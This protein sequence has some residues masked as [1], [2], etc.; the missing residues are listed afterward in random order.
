MHATLKR[1]AALDPEV[2]LYCHAPETAGPGL[3]SANLAYFEL[4]EQ[5]CRAALAS[6]APAEL[7]EDVDLEALVSF[8]FAE[9]VPPGIAMTQP[10][11][12]QPGHHAHIRLML[13]RLQGQ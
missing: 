8:P 1:M 10:Q 2:V 5:R 4:L 13:R 9:A 11:F 12:Y 6:G 3:L 7:V